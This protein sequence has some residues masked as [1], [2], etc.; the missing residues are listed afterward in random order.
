MKGP[1]RAASAV[2]AL[3]LASSL[4]LLLPHQAA[5]LTPLEHF[6]QWFRQHGGELHS[7]LTFQPASG[8]YRVVSHGTVKKEEVRTFAAAAVGAACINRMPLAPRCNASE[9]H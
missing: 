9:S 4:S 5:A 6:E 3:A 1:W 7:S 2:L 8:G